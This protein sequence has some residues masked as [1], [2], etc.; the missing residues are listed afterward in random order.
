MAKEGLFANDDGDDFCFVLS[1]FLLAEFLCA[2]LPVRP[3]DSN[4]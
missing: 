4:L 1:L 3:P 2:Y